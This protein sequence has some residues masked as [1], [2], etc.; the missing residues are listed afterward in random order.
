[1]STIFRGG[2]CI[3]LLPPQCVEGQWRDIRSAW[4][5][6]SPSPRPSPPRRGRGRG[7]AS[8]S[9]FADAWDSPTD[10]RGFPPSPAEGKR[11]G[12]R[13]LP[14]ERRFLG[15]GKATSF[16]GGR[17]EIG[18]LS[19]G[20]SCRYHHTRA[21]QIRNPRPETRKAARLGSCL[22]AAPRLPSDFGFRVFGET[23]LV[24]LTGCAH[25]RRNAR[26]LLEF[27]REYAY[28]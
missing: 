1:M 6:G 28:P 16:L 26:F 18:R 23:E 25:C 5:L 20:A 22:R 19:E 3:F 17:H 7:K 12:V 10:C 13:G 8:L 14:G 15:R 9:P 24:V 2:G 27:T 21:C 4:A 11:A